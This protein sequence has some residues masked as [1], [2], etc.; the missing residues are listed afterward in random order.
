M[1]KRKTTDIYKQ[2]LINKNI[3]V[4]CLGEYINNATKILHKCKRCEYTWFAR[5]DSILH[6]HLC[7]ICAF[8]LREKGNKK[9]SQDTFVNK[10]KNVNKNIKIIG[11]YKG[12]DK[13][14]K[15]QCLL[16][17]NIWNPMA[18]DI[19]NNHRGCP[20]CGKLKSANSRRKTH[21]EFLYDLYMVN[22]NIEALSEYVSSRIKIKCRCKTDGYEWD[23]TPNNLLSGKGC[24]RCNTPKGELAIA[25]FLDNKNI[26]YIRQYK[27]DD[28][29]NKNHLFFD[30]YLSDYNMCIEYDGEQHFE[31]VDFSSHNQERAKKQFE[32]IKLRDNIKNKY[33]QQNNI[34]LLRIPYWDFDNIEK[35][36]ENELLKGGG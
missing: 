22:P 33:C 17:N 20:E 2:E 12:I 31:I 5:P 6:N 13:N 3:Q 10:M 26:Y 16:C 7:P 11:E 9:F 23:S 18:N 28:C 25:K 30:F 34:K 8:E 35:I 14:I 36:L 15:C 24:P 4:E 29:K 32:K 27:F 21:I 1:G 19:L